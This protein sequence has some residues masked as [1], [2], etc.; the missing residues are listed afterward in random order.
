M[1]RRLSRVI[2][3]LL[4]SVG[5]A[6]VIPGPVHGGETAPPFTL[7]LLDG[8]TIAS[9]DLRGKLGVLQFMASW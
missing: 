1:G 8:G 4:A 2:G 5:F 6:F 7:K 9:D 3:S